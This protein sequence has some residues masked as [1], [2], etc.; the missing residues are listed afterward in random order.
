MPPFLL[1]IVAAIRFPLEE[2]LSQLNW[3]LLSYFFFTIY[4]AQSIQINIANYIVRITIKLKKKLIL[5]V[6]GGE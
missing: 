1:D 3:T 6:G 2:V 5:W 4:F